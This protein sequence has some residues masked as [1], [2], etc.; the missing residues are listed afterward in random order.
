M[1]TAPAVVTGAGDSPLAGTGTLL[2]FMLRRDRIKLPAWAGGFAL[3]IVYLTTALP[4][5]YPEEDLQAV[6]A[7]FGDPL[8][9]VLTGPGYGFDVPSYP[10]LVANGYGL[11]L[12]LLAALMSIL[13]VVRHTRAEEQSGRSELVRAN[14]VGRHAPLTAAMLMALVTN[15]AAGMA[16]FVMMLGAGGYETGGSALL[17]AAVAA[18]GLAFAGVAA[19]TVQLSQYSRAAAGMAGAVLGVAFLLRSG[20]D[21]A[22]VGGNALSWLSPL[23][24]GQQPAPFVLDRW[25]PLALLVGLAVV[26]TTVGYRLSNRRDLGAGL[27]AVRPGPS[28]AAPALGT[29]LGMA[30]R[31]QRGGIV[32]WT[33]SLAVSGVAFGG[34]ADTMLGALEDMP[35]TFRDM[36]GERDLLGGYMAYMA[37]FMAFLAAVYAVLALQGVRTEEMSGRADPVLGT[38][39]TRW[40]WLGANLVAIGGAVVV[41][42]VVA[43]AGTGA[44][45]AL[46]T[47]EVGLIGEGVA[48]HLNYVPAVLV[49]VAAATLLYGVLPRALPAVWVM[50]GYS[51]FV[52]TFGRILDLPQSAHDLSPF[53]HPAYMPF[54]PFRLAPLLVLAAIAVTIT[55]SGMLG[56]RRRQF[57]VR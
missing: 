22:R 46:V 20:G 39:I 40:Q 21:M 49:V 10:R 12:M 47:G 15:L 6:V 50:V 53:E 19:V 18:V 14:V 56:F 45:A 7:L 13:L 4:V 16:V 38:P 29:P 31:L 26:A 37:V 51:F 5:A 43:G 24:W 54:E 8:G 28:S 1:T 11:Y 30:L 36:F 23:G 48:A 57:N 32:G 52:G 44:G 55:A 25:W 34:F 2:R 33:L 17:A 9:R 27:M 41:M 3:F 35:E 42:L